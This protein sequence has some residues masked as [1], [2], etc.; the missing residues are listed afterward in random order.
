MLQTNLASLSIQACHTVFRSSFFE[1]DHCV[2]ILAWHRVR[3]VTSASKRKKNVSNLVELDHVRARLR[4]A[5]YQTQV[6]NVVSANKQALTRLFS[7]G[8]MFSFHGSKAA[9]DL[10]LAHQHLLRVVTSLNR[11]SAQSEKG[12]ARRMAHSESVFKEL[13]KLLARSRR[14]ALRTGTY[15]TRLKSDS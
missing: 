12:Q 13:D 10:L 15:L 8:A 1:V 5:A 3:F 4:L 6:A 9:R 14:I 2:E 7:T 11:L